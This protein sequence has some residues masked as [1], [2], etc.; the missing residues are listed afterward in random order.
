MCAG[1]E[2]HLMRKPLVCES[3]EAQFPQLTKQPLS[4]MASRTFQF[5]AAVGALE[6]TARLWK[7][8]A[9]LFGR[10]LLMALTTGGMGRVLSL[11]SPPAMVPLMV[12]SA[13]ST[14]TRTASI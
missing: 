3:L 12:T 10:L 7:G 8:R 2:S 4:I 11:C 13:T 9:I 6:T 1:L 14:D 5:T